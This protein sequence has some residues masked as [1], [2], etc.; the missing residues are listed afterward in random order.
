M[1]RMPA[2][3][4]AAAIF[5]SAFAAGASRWY[6]AVAFGGPYVAETVCALET[7]TIPLTMYGSSRWLLLRLSAAGLAGLGGLDSAKP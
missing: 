3:S 5:A 2:F 6:G 4:A 7:T 1:M